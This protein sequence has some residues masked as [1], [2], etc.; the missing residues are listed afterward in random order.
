M[1]NIP[2]RAVIAG[3]IRA[4]A[5]LIGAS[6]VSAE[7]SRPAVEERVTALKQSIAASHARLRQYEWIETTIIRFKGEEKDRKQ[8][9][10]FYGADGKVQKVLLSEEKAA[11][12]RGGRLKQKVIATKSAEMK[13]YMES[14]AKLIQRYVPPDAGDIDS[15][16]KREK[17]LLRPGDGRVRLDFADYIQAGDHMA[18]EVDPAANVLTGIS[19]NTYVDKPED[20]LR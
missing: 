20:E 10:C 18:I 13:D 5:C 4:S 2:G 11:P 12:P 8:Q 9:R 15:A 17:V 19:V 7:Q 1:S 6:T 3:V 14:A 16:K